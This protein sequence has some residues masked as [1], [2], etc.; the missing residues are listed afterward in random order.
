MRHKYK[1]MVG[2]LNLVGWLVGCRLDGWL[3]DSGD[4]GWLDVVVYCYDVCC[5]CLVGW[6]AQGVV[7]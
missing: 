7:G 6:L 5:Y 3:V 2:W 4:C 1:Y